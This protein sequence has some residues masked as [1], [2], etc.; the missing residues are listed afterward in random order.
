MHAEIC[1]HLTTRIAKKTK[2]ENWNGTFS[3]ER[4]PR[5]K[6]KEEGL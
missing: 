4:E 3:K 5:R 6:M 2:N 1:M